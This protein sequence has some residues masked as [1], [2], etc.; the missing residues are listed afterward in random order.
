MAIS[1]L[2]DS[3]FHTKREAILEQLRKWNLACLQNSGNLH[4][5]RHSEDSQ[6]FV[7]RQEGFIYKVEQISQKFCQTFL[8]LR[9]A[10]RGAVRPRRGYLLMSRAKK[11]QKSS[12]SPKKRVPENGS[13]LAW[14]SFLTDPLLNHLWKNPN[15]ICVWSR[16]RCHSVKIR[17]NP[18]NKQT[19]SSFYELGAPD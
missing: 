19:N 11:S 17:E 8:L 7:S 3:F 1:L 5:L 6:S 12:K 14:R 18:Y 4:Y 15:G 16:R 9:H 13:T 2:F 10:Y